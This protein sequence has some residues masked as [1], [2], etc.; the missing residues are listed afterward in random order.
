[1]ISG[2][3]SRSFTWLLIPEKI[4]DATKKKAITNFLTWMLAEGQNMTEA[5]AYARLPKPV[6]AKEQKAIAKIQ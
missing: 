3:P 1:M 5:L 4:G 2:F 6:V